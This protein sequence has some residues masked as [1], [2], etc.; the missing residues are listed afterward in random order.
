M[1]SPEY[2]P[3][4]LDTSKVELNED[5]QANI[6]AMARNNHEVWASNRAAEGWKPG[7]ARDDVRME[8]PG[9][10]S[11]DELSDGEKKIDRATVEQTLKTAVALGF[12]IRRRP[13]HKRPEPG[14]ERKSKPDD[15]LE[16]PP[17][18][19]GVDVDAL[20]KLEETRE[21]I[22][23]IYDDS[24]R[25]AQFFL[26]LHRRIAPIVAICGTGAVVMG[27]LQLY[28]LGSLSAA[29]EATL[30]L[31]AMVLVIVGVWGDF[32]R[33]WLV[34]RHRAERCRFLKFNFLLDMA[35]AG[36]DRDRLLGVA[37]QYKTQAESLETIDY[38][39]IEE[40]LVEDQVLRKPPDVSESTAVLADM[41]VLAQNY[42]R[43]RLTV[44]HDYFKGQAEQQM[45]SSVR[46]QD[47]PMLFFGASVY[48]VG[49]H[50]LIHLVWP[51]HEHLGRYLILAAAVLPILGSFVRAWRGIWES[52]RNT[53][54]FKAKSH[55]LNKLIHDLRNELSKQPK[56]LDLQ[57]LLWKG[58]QILE[59][60][61]RE[62][63]RLMMET[64]WIG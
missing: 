46:T 29:V 27:I 1:D 21:V 5:L 19:N 42:E 49:A 17:W 50:F 60:E 25:S 55:A 16:W 61:H 37:K 44:Q 41:W 31:I 56:A 6:E 23:D 36:R 52:S 24:N 43:T 33:N 40:W 7:P 64:E 38:E 13:P 47:I 34:R 51:T 28:G 62:W 53:L 35:S 12:E 57:H 10:V 54:R 8:H 45:R 58:E 20:A 26:K 22:G 14:A 15:M 4:P 2:K 3:H 39:G 59:G 63:L 11:Y 48:C 9:M 32:M 30:A 18:P